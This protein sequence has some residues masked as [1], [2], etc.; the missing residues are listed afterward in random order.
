MKSQKNIVPANEPVST[1]TRK[2]IS[3]QK[4]ENR[5]ELLTVSVYLNTGKIAGIIAAGIIAS[6]ALVSVITFIAM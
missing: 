5:N 2:S 1:K 4:R 6:A 3:E